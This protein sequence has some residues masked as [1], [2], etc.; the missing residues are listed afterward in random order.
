MKTIL[1]RGYGDPSRVFERGEA[2]VPTPGDD[3]VLVKI[4]ATSVNTPDCIATRGMPYALRL[5][6]GVCGPSSPVRGSDLAGVVVSTGARVTGFAPGDE[7]FGSVWTGGFKRGA[8]GTFC[9]YA[10]APAAQL[11]PKPAGLRFDQAAGAVMS[12]VTALQALRDVAGVRP[13]QRVLINGASGGIG[14]FA[15]QIARALGAEVT[16]VCS[17]RNVALVRELGAAHVVDYTQASFIEQDARYDAV[18]D[19]VMNH[20]PSAVARVLAPGGVLLL[21]SVGSDPWF[22]S[23]PSLALA[24]MSRSA[25]RRTVTFAPTRA[26]LDAI[27]AML[28]AG[29][30]RVVIDRTYPLAEAGAAVAHMLSRRARGQV[31]IQVA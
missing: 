14:T 12:G 8:Q 5:E 31:A 9:E 10:A 2:E 4:H 17:A 23:L 30:V 16:G 29:E 27:G 15:V 11:A 7:V 6:V 28:G 25:Q 22:G 24:A 3:E 26:N 1:Q 20:P 18:M 13:G 21:N 19:N